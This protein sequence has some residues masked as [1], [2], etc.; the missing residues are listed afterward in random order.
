MRD[1]MR[2]IATT[3][4]WSVFIA[5]AGVSLTVN[6]GPV[7]NMNGGEIVALVTVLMIGVIAMTYAI[8]HGGFQRGR[9]DDF[10]SPAR[11]SKPKRTRQDRISRLIDDLEDDEIYEL[12]ALLLDRERGE[13]TQQR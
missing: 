7:S 2:M 9:A 3:I 5:V 8:W 6:T 13:R 1:I 11:L 10:A 4:I 12:E